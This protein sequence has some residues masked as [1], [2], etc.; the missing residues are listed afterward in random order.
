MRTRDIV[1]WIE[2]DVSERNSLSGRRCGLCAAGISLE[3]LVRL[4]WVVLMLMLLLVSVLISGVLSFFLV[5]FPRPLAASFLLSVS[6]R[7]S[8]PVHVR[9]SVLPRPAREAQ[10]AQVRLTLADGTQ[11]T[12]QAQVKVRRS[13]VGGAR[14]QDG[15]TG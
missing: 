9:P 12:F 10:S 6:F 1:E 11:R 2:R 8:L 15:V 4:L 3:L 5:S 13:S 7:V 14:R